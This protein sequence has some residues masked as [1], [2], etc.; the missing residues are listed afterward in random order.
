MFSTGYWGYG[1][2]DRMRDQKL[3]KGK[4]HDQNH[5]IFDKI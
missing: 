5:L 4:V 1:A 3:S 2:E